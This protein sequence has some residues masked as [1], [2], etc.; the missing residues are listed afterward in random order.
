MNYNNYE[1]ERIRLELKLN[2][3]A[4][5]REYYNTDEA[6]T[7]FR[8]IIDINEVG[9]YHYDVFSELSPQDQN[10]YID[11][12]IGNEIARIDRWERL[13][14]EALMNVRAILFS[15][16]DPQPPPAVGSD[17]SSSSVSTY[18]DEEGFDVGFINEYDE[19]AFTR[20]PMSRTDTIRPL[21]L[22][23]DAR[24]DS[25][26]YGPGSPDYPPPDSEPDFQPSSPIGPPPGYDSGSPDY[27]PSPVYNPNSPDYAPSTPTDSMPDYEVNMGDVSTIRL[28]GEDSPESSNDPEIIDVDPT[29]P[30]SP[31]R[32]PPPRPPTIPSAPRRRR[33]LIIRSGGKTKRKQ[34]K[35]LTRKKNKRNATKKK[36]RK[37]KHAKKTKKR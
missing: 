31:E 12:H 28:D 22:P 32:T 2:D 11:E 15:W 4:E 8:S 24:P 23:E 9:L 10:L 21:I 3:V 30:G 5:E 33:R 29:P 17:S 26:D 36:K 25:P 7:D 27:T 35:G 16:D 34:K 13:N 6:R 1:D 20:G 14:Q 18:S 37:G 19:R